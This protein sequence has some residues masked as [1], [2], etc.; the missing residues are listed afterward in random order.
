MIQDPM[1][2]IPQ[3]EYGLRW[4]AVQDFME[5][6]D[7]DLILAYA[8][9]RATFGPAHARWL[10]NFPVHFE[11]VCI[12]IPKG[13]NPILLCG[14]ENDQ[15]ALTAG[16]IADVR[17]LAEFTHP[18]EDY[19]YSKIEGLAEIIPDITPKTPRTV[20]IAE[21]G[22]EAAVQAIGGGKRTR[23]SRGGGKRDAASR[24][25]GNRDR[26][27]RGLR[28]EHPAQK[29]TGAIEV[30]CRAQEACYREMQPGIQDR[31]VEDGF[32]ITESG[33]ERLNRTPYKICK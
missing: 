12:V 10:A 8:D 5:R 21:L 25:R 32:V 29:T 1:P 28:P 18:D 7:L 24:S 15:Y 22:L 9:D 20:G 14:P 19:P 13:R 17:I 6:R 26:H 16:R 27:H 3:A 2:F 4:A 23:G 31:R 30:A 11:P 33:A